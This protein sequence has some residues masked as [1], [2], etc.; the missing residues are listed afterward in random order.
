VPRGNS[1]SANV[2][3]ADKLNRDKTK[4]IVITAS[5]MR[6][7]P[8]LHPDVERVSSLRVLGVTV[9]DKLTAVDHVTTLLSSS[10]IA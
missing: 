4:E 5:R 10:S 9:N 7:P 3:A 2:W 1:A 8:P 6:A